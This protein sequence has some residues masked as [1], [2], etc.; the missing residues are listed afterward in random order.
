MAKYRIHI[1]KIDQDAPEWENDGIECDGFCLLADQD[2]GCAV[3]IQLLSTMDI[4]YMLARDD[5]MKC[6]M[7][8][9]RGLIEAGELREKQ[10]K[11]HAMDSI[12]SRIT[13]D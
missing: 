2:E 6:A 8:I 3:S 13:E 12:F 10:R 9:A 5:N 11:K 1:E 4:A 7:A